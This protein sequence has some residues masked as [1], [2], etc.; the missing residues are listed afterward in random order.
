V[1]RAHGEGLKGEVVPDLQEGREGPLAGDPGPKVGEGGV[2]APQDVEHQDAILHRVPKVTKSIRLA[3]HLPAVLANRQ[4]PLL[5][6]AEVGV[7]VDSTGLSIAEKLPL[8]C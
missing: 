2:E 3:L 6:G 4:V 8:E 7:E 5:E 1:P